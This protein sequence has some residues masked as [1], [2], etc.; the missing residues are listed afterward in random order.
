MAKE[1]TF[2]F[3]F[4]LIFQD[5]KKCRLHPFEESSISLSSFINS[6]I[7]LYHHLFAVDDIEALLNL[8]YFLS[9]YVVDTLRQNV[10]LARNLLDSV[11]HITICAVALFAYDSACSIGK[12]SLI[13]TQQLAPAC[14]FIGVSVIQQP[15]YFTASQ[16]FFCYLGTVCI[17]ARVCIQ[18]ITVYTSID[19]SIGSVDNVPVIS[20]GY[21]S[22][23]EAV[24]YHFSSTRPT[25]DTS[26]V[27]G[28]LRN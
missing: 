3:H 17:V 25:S 21:C 10:G 28:S 8:L 15:A 23:E 18:I 4:F 9:Q 12:G 20:L 19:S 7:L 22:S 6:R 14:Q 26:I 11:C 16:L 5:L 24:A 27:G 13:G 2:R 1:R